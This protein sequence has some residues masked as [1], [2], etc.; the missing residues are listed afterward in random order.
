M[1]LVSAISGMC[2]EVAG[3]RAGMPSGADGWR[4]SLRRDGGDSAVVLAGASLVVAS[5]DRQRRPDW[6]RFRARARGPRAMD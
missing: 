6:K 5:A 1:V 2:E 3:A 4:G